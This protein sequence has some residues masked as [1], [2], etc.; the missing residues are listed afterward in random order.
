VK[1][2]EINARIKNQD[3]LIMEKFTEN[4]VISEQITST[5]VIRHFS[6]ALEI[7][8]LFT[9]HPLFTYGQSSLFL[10]RNKNNPG[11]QAI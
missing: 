6:L 7:E 3:N 9:Q 10:Q 5:A 1:H 11:S 2:I 8:S 4:R